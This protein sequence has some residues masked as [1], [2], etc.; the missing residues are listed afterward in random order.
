MVE[1]DKIKDNLALINS[2]AKKIKNNTTGQNKTRANSI[3]SLVAL[4]TPY[5]EAVE[6][7]V[8]KN[9][10]TPEQIDGALNPILN[11]LKGRR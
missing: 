1:I 5:I 9:T 2:A 6:N 7:H 11:R 3:I 8:V 4:T 10:I